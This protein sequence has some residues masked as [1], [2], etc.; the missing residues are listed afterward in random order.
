LVGGLGL[1]RAAHLF[2]HRS[3]LWMPP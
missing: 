2:G 3:W 1:G